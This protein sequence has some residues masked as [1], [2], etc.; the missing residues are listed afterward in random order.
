MDRREF[1]QETC[2]PRESSRASESLFGIRYIYTFVD[3]HTATHVQMYVQTIGSGSLKK[4]DT[5]HKMSYSNIRAG[6]FNLFLEGRFCIF[7]FCKGEY[8]FS[9]VHECL[10]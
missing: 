7:F 10:K 5:K 8:L 6:I 2:D 3:L 9:D 1:Y 4:C